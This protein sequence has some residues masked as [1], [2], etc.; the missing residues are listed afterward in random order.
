[1]RTDLKA[2]YDMACRVDSEVSELLI[3][4]RLEKLNGE[5]RTAAD[6]A[7]QASRSVNGSP[8]PGN[9]EGKRPQG[10]PP[11][12]QSYEADLEED[13]RNAVRAASALA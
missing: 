7:R 6:K 3:N 2:A 5:K 8:S 1:M 4:E 9:S 11:G 12:S 10:S 13:V